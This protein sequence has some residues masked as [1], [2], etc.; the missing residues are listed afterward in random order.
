[1]LPAETISKLVEVLQLM[2][3]LTRGGIDVDEFDFD[4]YTDE[5]NVKR[6]IEAANLPL[7]DQTILDQV[8]GIVSDNQGTESDSQQSIEE[9]ME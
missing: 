7:T 8:E 6:W 5:K 2:L 1:M 9:E 4:H 3:A